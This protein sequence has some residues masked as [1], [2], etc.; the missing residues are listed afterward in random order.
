MIA[1]PPPYVKPKKYKHDIVDKAQRITG[2]NTFFRLVGALLPNMKLVMVAVIPNALWDI[3]LILWWGDRIETI[4]Q[5]KDAMA[6]YFA[7]GRVNAFATLILFLSFL[8]ALSDA[9]IGNNTLNHLLNK[10]ETV[11]EFYNT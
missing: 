5:N 11:N 1:S 9:M 6:G 8:G 4:H 7:G 3:D 2:C 10:P